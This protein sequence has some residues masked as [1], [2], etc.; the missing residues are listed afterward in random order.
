MG[1]I[2]AKE[3]VDE[4][5]SIKG[6]TRGI[7]LKDY[8]DYILSEK[9][10][11]GLEKLEKAM[12]DLGHP[13]KYMELDGMKFYPI[14]LEALTLLVIKGVFNLSDEEI[15]EMGRCH[16]K[17]SILIRLF[18]KHFFSVK[19]TAKVVPKMWRSFYSFGDAKTTEVDEEKGYAVLRVEEFKLI[20][21]HC[22]YFSGYISSILQLI[23][24]K[25]VKC[26]ERKCV[27][28][29]DDYHEFLLEW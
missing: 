3:K 4:L 14:G 13:I 29:G 5:M 12:A 11:E 20:P 15:K 10:E 23:V 6:E 9:G 19:G 8:A 24:G 21:L 17:V 18:M 2:V 28:R 26:K 16:A 22:L 7:S 1:Q 27:Y 25:E